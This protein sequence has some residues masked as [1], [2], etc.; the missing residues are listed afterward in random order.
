MV[1]WIPQCVMCLDSSTSSV[2]SRHIFKTHEGL[3]SSR[4]VYDC[5][6]YDNFSYDK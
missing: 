2:I 3:S 1:T 6:T 5:V 4:S